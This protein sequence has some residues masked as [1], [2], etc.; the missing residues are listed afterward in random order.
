MVNFGWSL[1]SF[2]RKLFIS[3]ETKAQKTKLNFKVEFINCRDGNRVYGSDSQVESN[4]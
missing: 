4:G 2:Y 3:E 1:S